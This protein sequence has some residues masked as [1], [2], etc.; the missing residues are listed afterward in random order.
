MDPIQARNDETHRK[1]AAR[2]RQDAGVIAEARARLE[3]W[4][5]RDGAPIDPA[6]EEW[7]DALDMMDAQDLAEFLES[8]SPRA[9]RMRISS[10]FVAP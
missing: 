7:L 6:L 9:K 2:I 10:P 5:E 8:T 1:V 4:I 3:R